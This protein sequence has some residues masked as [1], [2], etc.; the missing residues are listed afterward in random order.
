[1]IILVPRRC[2][3]RWKAWEVSCM[4]SQQESR[5]HLS[6]YI[7]Y[8]DDDLRSEGQLIR[9]SENCPVTNRWLILSLF[10]S[11]LCRTKN[12]RD[13]STYTKPSK[14]SLLRLI[15]TAMKSDLADDNETSSFSV[16]TVCNLLRGRSARWGFHQSVR[17]RCCRI[18]DI[19]YRRLSEL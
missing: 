6:H 7:Y 14:E 4:I 16:V 19:S 2:R 9:A 3:G 18:R 13:H 15:T 10:N 8:S 11:S 17:F 12:L 5:F 1:M